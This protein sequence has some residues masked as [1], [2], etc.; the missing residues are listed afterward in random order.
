LLRTLLTATAL[1]ALLTAPALPQDTQIVPPPASPRDAPVDPTN[2]MT[3]TGVAGIRPPMVMSQG[4]ALIEGDTLATRV[5]GAKVFTGT[6]ADAETIGDISDLVIDANGD[7]AAAVI[8]VGGFLGV[9]EKLVA[10]D[11]R[12]LALSLGPDGAPRY[13]LAT[14]A[15]AL[16]AAPDFTYDDET[17]EEQQQNLDP[18]NAANAAN[19]DPNL[20]T[21]QPSAAVG[22]DRSTMSALDTSGLTAEEL[23]GI[24]VFG[25]NN[26][27]IGTIGDF[28]LNADGTLDAV[29]VDVG[30]FLGLGKKPVAVGFDNLDV[31]VDA[32]NKRYLFLNT[33]KQQLEAQPE[34]NRDTY[35]AERDAQRLVVSP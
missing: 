34:F 33:T 29:I 23:K 20:T 13:V 22:P 8:G 28:M 27:Q 24:A 10:V 3:E 15:D 14:N 17:A 25:V 16:L 26:E 35:M 6:G 5:L 32:D 18:D 4:Y 11:F 9:G 12:E 2:G 21:D 1:V 7:I 30:G 31:S 19:A